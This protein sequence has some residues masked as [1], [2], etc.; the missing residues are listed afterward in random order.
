[1]RKDYK[2]YKFTFIINV[3]NFS[4]VIRG[5]FFALDIDDIYNKLPNVILKYICSQ[6]VSHIRQIRVFDKNNQ[7][8]YFTNWEDLKYY[9]TIA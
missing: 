9:S 7:I 8:A 2:L 5:K 4:K 3:D 6:I 1:M